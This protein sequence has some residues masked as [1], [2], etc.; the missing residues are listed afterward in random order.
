MTLEEYIQKETEEGK[1][2]FH[3]R[4]YAWNEGVPRFYIHPQYKD[5]ETLDFEVKGNNLIPINL[6]SQ[7]SKL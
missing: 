4:V 5:G 1:F 3:I 2:D 7:E 6:K